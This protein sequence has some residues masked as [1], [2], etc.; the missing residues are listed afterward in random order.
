MQPEL[1]GCTMK[2]ILSSDKRLPSGILLFIY[3]DVL[4]KEASALARNV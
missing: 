3:F 2:K 4:P 1:S